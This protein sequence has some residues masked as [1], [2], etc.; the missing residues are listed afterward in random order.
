LQRLPSLLAV[1]GVRSQ[2][3]WSRRGDIVNKVGR[4]ILVAT[5]A[6][7]SGGTPQAQTK[8]TPTLEDSLSLRT[9]SG[10]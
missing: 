1:G 8:H 10:A 5:L 6:F 4:W 7:L 9:I 3:I 2:T